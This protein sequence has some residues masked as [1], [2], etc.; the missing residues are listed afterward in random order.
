MKISRKLKIAYTSVASKPGQFHGS[1]VLRTVNWESVAALVR[2]CATD[3]SPEV[4][5]KSSRY[6]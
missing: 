5:S 4:M 1:K 3:R 2:Q 6:I